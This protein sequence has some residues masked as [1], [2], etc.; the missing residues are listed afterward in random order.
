MSTIMSN[1]LTW[2]GHLAG[3]CQLFPNSIY[4][5]HI[6]EHLGYSEIFSTDFS[7]ILATLIHW[8]DGLRKGTNSV[9]PAWEVL[10]TIITF[11]KLPYTDHS[12]EWPQ[13]ACRNWWRY[14]QTIENSI[15]NS[16]TLSLSLLY[17]TQDGID[18]TA[19][20]G[21]THTRFV[22]VPLQ[23]HVHFSWCWAGVASK[24]A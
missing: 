7:Y 21:K 9:T 3:Y 4:Y 6:I 14:Y 10:W 15:D 11:Y 2:K 19:R 17:I 20:I 16:T 23:I 18:V 24:Q 13:S 8:T 12:M 22:A 1:L 5:E